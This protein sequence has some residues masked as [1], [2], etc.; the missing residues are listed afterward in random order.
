MFLND[1]QRYGRLWP[2]MIARLSILIKLLWYRDKVSLVSCFAIILNLMMSSNAYDKM[3]DVADSWCFTVR[4]M[5]LEYMTRYECNKWRLGWACIP[6]PVSSTY[7]LTDWWFCL[8]WFWVLVLLKLVYDS[9]HTLN[10]DCP[11]IPTCTTDILFV[12]S[13]SLDTTYKPAPLPACHSIDSEPGLPPTDVAVGT[14][15][16]VLSHSTKVLFQYMETW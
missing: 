6:D 12:S 16:A 2:R 5:R 7:W 14:H 11:F 1:I 3:A 4:R 8:R 13:I 9:I 10:G 15:L